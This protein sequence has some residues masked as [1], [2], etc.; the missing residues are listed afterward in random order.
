M[1][2][3]DIADELYDELPS[4]FIAAR[5]AAVKRAK[6]EGDKDLATEI[7]RLTKPSVGAWAVNALVRHRPEIMDGVRALG[8]SLREA[9]QDLDSDALRSLVQQRRKVVGQLGDE[10]EKLGAEL[11]QKLSSSAREELEQTLGAALADADATSAVLTGRLVRSLETSGFDA[12]DLDGAVA[13]GPGTPS[14]ARSQPRT[15]KPAK[16]SPNDIEVAR[17]KRERE[18]AERRVE[19]DEAKKAL[20]AA[21]EAAERSAAEHA[22]AKERRNDLRDEI[23]ELQRRLDQLESDLSAAVTEV[24]AAAAAQDDADDAESQARRRA[25]RAD[26]RLDALE[27]R[28]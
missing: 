18:L 16:Q 22:S 17:A 4:E 13:G 7:G 3:V 19:A 8:E 2:L 26:E 1:A 20:D 10:A 14:S 27:R 12:V 23:A 5:T 21:A 11:G 25:D 24:R 9:Q 28:R 15:K 6:S